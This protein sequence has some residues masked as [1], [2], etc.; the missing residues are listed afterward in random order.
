M[1]ANKDVM[2]SMLIDWIQDSL[3]SDP[4]WD[5]G[6]DDL[7]EEEGDDLDWD[8]NQDE[9]DLNPHYESGDWEDPDWDE[10]DLEGDEVYEAAMEEYESHYSSKEEALEAFTEWLRR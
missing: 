9:V 6:D 2:S 8:Y 3:D 10:V 4:R 7:D 1:N 5:D